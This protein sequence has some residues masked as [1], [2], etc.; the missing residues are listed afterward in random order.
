MSLSSGNSMSIGRLSEA[1]DL[2]EVQDEESKV[3][4]DAREMSSVPCFVFGLFSI[5]KRR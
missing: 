2:I 3:D 4:C 5:D 1:V